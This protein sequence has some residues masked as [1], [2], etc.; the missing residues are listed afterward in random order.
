MINRFF[1]YL[2]VLLFFV[3]SCSSSQSEK[4]ERP[5]CFGK[6][7]KICKKTGDTEYFCSFAGDFAGENDAK[8][9]AIN[10]VYKNFTTYS[11]IY[12]DH[13]RSSK[14]HSTK[15][16]TDDEVR[17][18]Y[19][20]KFD[21]ITKTYTKGIFKGVI[22]PKVY[23]ESYK[24]ENKQQKYRAWAHAAVSIQKAQQASDDFSKEISE[25]YT[26]RL[27]P[28]DSLCNILE[29]YGGIL[30]A[31]NKDPFDKM[32]ASYYSSGKKVSLYDYAEQEMGKIV[33]S[34]SFA[35][36][37]GRK[38]KKQK[39]DDVNVTVQLNSDYAKN[40][41]NLECSIVVEGRNFSYKDI[42]N[43]TIREGNSFTL[44]IP[45]KEL[46]TGKY[47][48]SFELLLNKITGH[49]SSD[50]NPK[51]NFSFEVVPVTAEIECKGLSD[52]EKNK[53]TE[54]IRQGLENNNVKI[55]IGEPPKGA[56][57]RYSFVVTGNIRPRIRQGGPTRA[58]ETLG[59]DIYTTVEF[60]CSDDAGRSVLKQLKKEFFDNKR[61]TAF[62]KII[63]SI[64]DDE[65]FFNYVKKIVE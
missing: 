62:N 26:N 27:S 24:D 55:I 7:G 57:K 17:N 52:S 59:Y 23:S 45:T 43:R 65:Q 22:N 16:E 30:D 58:S 60:V 40:F 1:Q 31:L 8:E 51:R 2:I 15:E 33:S 9:A 29:S 37:E 3:L 11:L 50:K 46:E 42:R 63:T 14:T 53:I 38:Q 64:Q 34:V 12:I 61:D 47:K 25:K 41:A 18:T 54:I 35:R 49:I 13:S 28:Q 48:V 32:V 6:F 5:P 20:N 19:I 39:T 56:Q 44:N 10:E 21:E 36:F 4:L